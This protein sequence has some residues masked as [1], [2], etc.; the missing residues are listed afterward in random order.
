MGVAAIANTTRRSVPVIKT[1]HA[2]RYTTSAVNRYV[3]TA[4][5]ATVFVFPRTKPAR[6]C[7]GCVQMRPDRVHHVPK[8]ASPIIEKAS[9][10]STLVTQRAANG[11][12]LLFVANIPVPQTGSASAGH[13]TVQNRSELLETLFE[14]TAVPPRKRFKPDAQPDRVAQLKHLFQRDVLRDAFTTAATEMGIGNR[15]L[16]THEQLEL[17]KLL[18]YVA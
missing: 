2:H 5:R 14:Q 3:W 13:K 7:V 18:K 11:K 16:T 15:Q 6:A 9:N 1:V 10:K 17:K 4:A 12:P 8:D